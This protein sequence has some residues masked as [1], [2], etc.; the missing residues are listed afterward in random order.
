MKSIIVCLLF[1]A[2]L[3]TAGE[4]PTSKKINNE[5]IPAESFWV[6]SEIGMWMASYNVWYKIDKKSSTVKLSYNKKKWQ[7][8]S[9][10]VWHD[11]HGR[12]FCIAEN[13]IMYS[14]NGKNWKE[15][16]NRTWQDLN[17]NWF[18]FDSNF[19]LYEVIQ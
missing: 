12:W 10:A 13:K 5:S 14:D 9:D 3:L 1:T 16:V 18:R 6:K 15:V 2:G 19:D 11:N 7:I 4:L 17:G 8:S